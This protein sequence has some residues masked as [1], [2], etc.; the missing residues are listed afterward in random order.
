MNSR[1]HPQCKSQLHTVVQIYNY[2]VAFT[3]STLLRLTWAANYSMVLS[4]A[5]TAS[6]GALRFLPVL[7]RL[8]I[9]PQQAQSTETHSDSVKFYVTLR[10]CTHLFMKTCS[11]ALCIPS[12]EWVLNIL[13]PHLH[14]V[15]L[16]FET[17]VWIS[18][19]PT[20]LSFGTHHHRL[21]ISTHLT[22]G[23][24]CYHPMQPPVSRPKPLTAF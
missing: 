22:R 17:D 23:A 10:Y 11:N 5:G 16:T 1:L 9:P 19:S 14:P 15:H 24:S 20:F 21:Y 8:S 18:T 2:E 6:A 7:P 13:E 3:L 4:S 12:S